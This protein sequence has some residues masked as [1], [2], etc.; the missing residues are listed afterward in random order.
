MFDKRYYCRFSIRRTLTFG[1]F[2]YFVYFD[3]FLEIL[4][5]KFFLKIFSFGPSGGWK[6]LKSICWLPVGLIDER[7]V[8]CDHIKNILKTIRLP[9]QCKV[10]KKWWSI[11]R[12]SDNLSLFRSSYLIR[13][14]EAGFM[15][16]DILHCQTSTR[17]TCRPLTE[18]PSSVSCSLSTD[19]PG[20]FNQ[21]F[22]SNIR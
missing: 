1:S 14:E 22:Q 5:F 4:K 16:P 2:Q 8:I 13:S 17:R 10:S 3:R 15:D 18:E 9:S 7:K 12:M 20:F 19:L 21:F 6:S 11:D